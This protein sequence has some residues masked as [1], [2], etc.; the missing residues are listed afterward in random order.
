MENIADT[1][2][3]PGSLAF[4]IYNGFTLSLS[5]NCARENAVLIAGNAE[6]FELMCMYLF[7]PVPPKNSTGANYVICMVV[8]V[9]SFFLCGLSSVQAA[10]CGL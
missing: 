4:I 9:L 2:V 6:K 8:N 5:N 1:P 10:Y 7:G 3:G